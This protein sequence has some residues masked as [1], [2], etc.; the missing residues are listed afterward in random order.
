MKAYT[1]WLPHH[2]ILMRLLIIRSFLKTNDHYLGVLTQV[3]QEI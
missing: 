1:S 2:P 3:A